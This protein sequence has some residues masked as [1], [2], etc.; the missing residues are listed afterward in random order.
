MAVTLSARPSGAELRAV[1]AEGIGLDD[2]RA[3]LDVGLVHAQDGFGLREVQF[4]EAA[5]HAYGFKQHGAHGAVGDQDRAFEPLLEVVDLHL[6]VAACCR[7][8][9]QYSIAP[10][11]SL[12]PC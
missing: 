6:A 3:G 9:M 8:V 2:L 11:G 4:L 12:R 10:S 1:G 5:L 7:Q